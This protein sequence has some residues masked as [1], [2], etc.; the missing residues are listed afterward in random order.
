[1]LAFSIVACGA[2]ENS[3]NTNDNRPP[4]LPNGSELYQQN[5]VICHGAGGDAAINGAKNL[6]I[7]ALT[8]EERTNRIAN[9]KGL[10]TPFKNI[11]SEAEIK[12]VAEYTMN[13]K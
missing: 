1:M 11:L 9:G 13:L 8:L 7:S 5:C 6:K 3:T 12:A 4:E 10:M 2:P